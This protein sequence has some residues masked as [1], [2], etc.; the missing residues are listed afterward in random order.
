MIAVK[1]HMSNGEAI[2]AA[3]DHELLGLTFREGRM[4]LHVSE[5]F[6]NGEALPDEVLAGGAAAIGGM[7][8]SLMS[9]LRAADCDVLEFGALM[10]R[11]CYDDY[12]NMQGSAVANAA[13]TFDISLRSAG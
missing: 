8:S 1:M 12:V 13:T 9:A 4:R 3:C 11:F 10:H 2:L 6:Y 7:F 5:R